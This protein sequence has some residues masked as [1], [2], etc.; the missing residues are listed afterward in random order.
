M[1]AP[2]GHTRTMSS[3]PSASTPDVHRVD[4]GLVDLREVLLGHEVAQAD[5]AVAEVEGVEPL[6]GFALAARDRVERLLHRRG[7]LVVDEVGEVALEQLHLGERGPRGDE[8][9][10]L[11]EHVVAAEDG[12]DHRRVRRRAS[13]AAVLELLH[14][15]RLG[16]ARRRLGGVT[17]RRA[18]RGTRPSSPSSSGGRIASRSS[19]SASGSSAPST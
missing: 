7:E 19:S 16:V 11:L 17:R 15:A 2:L 6:L 18:A 10:A 14:Q 4:L 1:L 5:L 3:R 13:D 9:A 12:L 8:R